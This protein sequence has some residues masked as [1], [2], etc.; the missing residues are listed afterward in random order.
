MRFD[1]IVGNPPFATQ[2]KGGP[3]YLRCVDKTYESFNKKMIVIMPLAFID[4]MTSSYIRYRD[5]FKTRLKYVKELDSKKFE[6]TFMDNCG[7]YEFVDDKKD[8]SLSIEDINDHIKKIDDLSKVSRFTEYE[9]KFVKL[10][11]VD[12]KNDINSHIFYSKTDEEFDSI[13]KLKRYHKNFIVTANAAHGARNAEFFSTKLG[14]IFSYDNIEEFKEDCKSRNGKVCNIMLFDTFEGAKNCIDAMRRPLLRFC[15]YR[16]QEDQNMKKKCYQYVPN[17]DWSDDKT[18]T[19]EGILEMCG[20]DKYKIDEY[21]RY[22]E[23]YVMKRDEERIAR[24]ERHKKKD[25]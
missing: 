20:C 18:K 4:R 12:D 13:Y 14:K 22:C 15:L 9:E 21:V 7:I 2:A 1:Y 16:V 11:K 5:K 8:F 17:I 6:G 19:D 23:E 3:L 10:L 25:N 24:L